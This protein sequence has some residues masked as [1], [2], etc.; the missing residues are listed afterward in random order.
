VEKDKGEK[1]NKEAKNYEIV[2]VEEKTLDIN[3]KRWVKEEQK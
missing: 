3:K 1:R 2:E